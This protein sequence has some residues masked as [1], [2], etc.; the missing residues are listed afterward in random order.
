MLS[1][2]SLKDKEKLPLIFPLSLPKENVVNENKS[3]QKNSQ[4]VKCSYAPMVI[5]KIDRGSL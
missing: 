2:I 1:R 4:K 5:N 3:Y